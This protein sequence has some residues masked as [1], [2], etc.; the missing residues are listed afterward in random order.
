MGTLGTHSTFR[1][2]LAADSGHWNL[3]ERVSNTAYEPQQP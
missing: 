3:N 2:H 1:I